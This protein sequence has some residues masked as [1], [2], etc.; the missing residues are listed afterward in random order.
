M[1]RPPKVDAESFSEDKEN[2]PEVSRDLKLKLRPEISTAESEDASDPPMESLPLEAVN[3][4]RLSLAQTRRSKNGS[5]RLL[6]LDKSKESPS[7]Q[8]P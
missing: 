2:F 4:R 8:R 6:L 3:L 7:R 5:H 1:L